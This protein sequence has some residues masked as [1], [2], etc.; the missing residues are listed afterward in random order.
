MAHPGVQKVMEQ[1][2]V[3]LAGPVKV[4]SESYY[5]ERYQG[6]VCPSGGNP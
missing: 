6:L 2:E 5:P 4:F 1:G 3:N